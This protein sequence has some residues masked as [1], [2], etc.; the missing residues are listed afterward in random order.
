MATQAST[1]QMRL[2][3]THEQGKK[4]IANAQLLFFLVVSF[5]SASLTSAYTTSL[6]DRP[7][8][9]N[10]FVRHN[11]LGISCNH[12]HSKISTALSSTPQSGEWS[13]D[14]RRY[15]AFDADAAVLCERLN[16]MR[17][18]ILEQE[19][20][21]PP[22]P[23]LSPINFVRQV[24]QAL[25]DPDV[26]LPDSG[27][28]LLLRSSSKEWRRLLLQSVAAPDFADET[29][30]SSALGSAMSRPNNKFRILVGTDEDDDNEEENLYPKETYRVSFSAEPLDFMDGTCWLTCQLRDKNDG[31]L[32]VT[33]GWQLI[34]REEDGAWLIDHIDWKD[35]REAF[36]PNAGEEQRVHACRR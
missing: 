3:F 9:V 13:N 26:P 32:L 23:A 24:L 31:S 1:Q 18:T 29:R 5:G 35:F 16:R 21:R 36:K 20:N 33:M 6:S 8:L 17:A 34:R 19:M 30:V 22:N 14:K 2:S 7:Q 11:C 4:K 25:R 15:S 27:F 10:G 28:R 12:P